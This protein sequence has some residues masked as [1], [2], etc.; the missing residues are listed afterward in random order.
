MSKQK[1]A[2]RLLKSI[3]DIQTS[4]IEEPEDH[5]MHPKRIALRGTDG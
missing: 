2:Y 4:Y 5:T 1:K 3:G